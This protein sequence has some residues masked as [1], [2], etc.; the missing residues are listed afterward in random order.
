MKFGDLPKGKLYFTNIT[1]H[2][3]ELTVLRD[4]QGKTNI[5]AELMNFFKRKPTLAYQ[6]DKFEIQSGSVDF[7]QNKYLAG[8]NISI[9]QGYR[10]GTGHKQRFKAIYYCP[11]Q[12]DRC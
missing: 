2:S 3:P 9:A 10:F 8:N 7:N 1:V 6:I 5:S 12:Q 4:E 11:T